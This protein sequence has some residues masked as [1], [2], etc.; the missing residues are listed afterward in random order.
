MDEHSEERTPTLPALAARLVTPHGV[1]DGWLEVGGDR[2]LRIA[3][4]DPPADAVR[5]P[6]HIVVPGFVDL[7]HHGGGGHSVTAGDPAAVIGAVRFHRD[8]G[9]TTVLA[10]LVTAPVDELTAASRGIAALLSDGCDA[11]PDDVRRLLVGI[12]LEGPFLATA[13]CGA[14]DPA[15]MIDPT[16]EV[17]D[18]LV[19]AGGGWLRS[20]T[21]AP[22]RS[23]AASAIAQ[24]V[25]RG[26]IAAI[27][28]TD[29]RTSDCEIAIAAGATLATHLGNA[30]RPLHHREPGPIGTCLTAPSVVCELIVDGHHLH[31]GL[32]RLAHQAKG[33]DGVA[34]ITD[35]I[36]AAGVGDGR[37][38]LGGHPVEVR[39][40]VARLLDADALAGST[41]TME[42]AFRN[43]VGA[44]LSLDQAARA[45]STNP[46][47]VLGLAD[48]RG[49]I[50]VGR[51][52]DLAV[53]DEHL[54][55]VAV[56][57]SGRVVA[58][59]LD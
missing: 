3:D 18:E 37:Y 59:S 35:A 55:L 22:E 33:D 31:D 42:V 14:Q 40:G 9:T 47:R 57:V 48:E 16:A 23:G 44:G 10:S 11:G 6:R 29:A 13:R 25:D 7:H 38:E 32:V 27:G 21:I 15:H 28:H 12:H 36:S 46:A 30:M 58:G 49:S 19:A 51:R 1:V 17:V 41:L 26:V 53:F 34:L 8:H 45:A 5:R 4:D 39:G 20:V 52:A 24:L 2:I 50:V 56:V 54:A 43:A